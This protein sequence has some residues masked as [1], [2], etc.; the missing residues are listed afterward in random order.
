MNRTS[1]SIVKRL[2]EENRV[3]VKVAKQIWW[4]ESCK[5]ACLLEKELKASPVLYAIER[6]GVAKEEGLRL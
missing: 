6:N 2:S 1:W 4:Q 3:S 5:R